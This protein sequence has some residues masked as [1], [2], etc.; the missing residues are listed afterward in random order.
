MLNYRF[1]LND[2]HGTQDFTAPWDE[3]S[4]LVECAVHGKADWHDDCV[5]CVRWSDALDGMA[6]QGNYR[7]WGYE[8]CEYHTRQCSSNLRIVKL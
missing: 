3:I 1:Q 2:C 4:A 8:E 7:N 6:H 5:N